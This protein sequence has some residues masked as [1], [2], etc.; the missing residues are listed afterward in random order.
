MPLCHTRPAGGD[1]SALIGYAQ[2]GSGGLGGFGESTGGD[3]GPPA[4]TAAP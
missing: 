2:G 4:V 3:G 1:S